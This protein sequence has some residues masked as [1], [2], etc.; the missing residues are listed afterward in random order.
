MH[1]V[2]QKA[3]TSYCGSGRGAL[4]GKKAVGSRAIVPLSRA[5]MVQRSR[6][7][8]SGRGYHAA[9]LA[10]LVPTLG[11]S[12]AC[13]SQAASLPLIRDARAS[14]VGRLG[15]GLHDSMRR[16]AKIAPAPM[17]PSG[18]R[19]RPP[20]IAGRS[21]SGLQLTPSRVPLHNSSGREGGARFGSNQCS[22]SR[23]RMF[24]LQKGSHCWCRLTPCLSW[25]C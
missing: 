9:G 5:A 19:L 18:L 14:G 7:Y 8:S 21:S 4:T 3:W 13:C 2:L 25:V 12:C 23:P 22:L 17:S 16:L 20:P 6:R 24:V 11:S 10:G 15:M 1:A